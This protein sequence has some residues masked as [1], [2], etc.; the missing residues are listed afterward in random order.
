MPDMKWEEKWNAVNALTGR[1]NPDT[2]LAHMFFRNAVGAGAV[3]ELKDA[4]SLTSNGQSVCSN[5]AAKN[6]LEAQQQGIPSGFVNTPTHSMAW[7]VDPETK[8]VI[9]N[10][11][12]KDKF[13]FDSFQDLADYVTKNQRTNSKDP[14]ATIYFATPEGDRINPGKEQDQFTDFMMKRTPAPEQSLIG[15]VTGAL[16]RM[17]GLNE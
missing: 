9:L 13:T 15:R 10:S 6:V 11:N 14:N 2:N 12:D 1:A 16:K 3:G 8:K 5:I 7:T 17:T 4:K